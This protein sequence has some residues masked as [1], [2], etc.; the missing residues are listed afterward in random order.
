M[1]YDQRC[2]EAFAGAYPFPST[3][4]GAVH[5]ISGETL[6]ELTDNIASRLS[7]IEDGT[8]GASL[9]ADFAANLDHSISRFNTFATSGDDQDFGRGA[10]AYDRYWHEVFSPMA[11]DSGHGPHRFPNITM[12]PLRNEG[13]YYAMMLVAGALD[14]CGGPAINARAQVLGSG[15]E[16][17]PG[18]YAAGNCVASPSK[19]AYF[20]AGHTLGMAVT[21]GYIAARAALEQ[22]G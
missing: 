18:L 11:A 21:F 22:A 12:H 16:P 4:T 2:A 20:G 17:I 1:V 6:E 10:S 15:G 14:T 7:E 13:P 8:G 3:P 19:E 5:V 9:D